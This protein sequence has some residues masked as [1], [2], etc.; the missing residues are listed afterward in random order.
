MDKP[1]SNAEA[2]VCGL[3]MSNCES[4]REGRSQGEILVGT[5]DR[6]IDLKGR[7][8][9]IVCR[10]QYVIH[11]FAGNRLLLIEF[12]VVGEYLEKL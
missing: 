3:S 7:L 2:G 6:S 8:I 4:I 11:V 9:V 12:I 5:S 10:T 1:I